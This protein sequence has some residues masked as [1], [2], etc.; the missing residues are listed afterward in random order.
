MNETHADGNGSPADNDECEPVSCSNSTNHEIGR[1][2][3][4][5]VSIPSITANHS[6][7][8]REENEES[9]IIMI[10]SQININ[11]H[12]SDSRNT[13]INSISQCHPTE[14]K[15]TDR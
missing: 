12:S 5:E 8:P 3:E 13:D 2:F 15:I 7:V 4:K 10:S 14:R 6:G 9:N 1:Q 11:C